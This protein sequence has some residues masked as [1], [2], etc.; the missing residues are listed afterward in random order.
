MC[1]MNLIDVLASS[2]HENNM[3]HVNIILASLYYHASSSLN[4]I[5]VTSLS[6]IA[7]TIGHSYFVPSTFARY[8]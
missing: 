1:S 7:F 3:K 8:D 2:S 4:T 6:I 5:T